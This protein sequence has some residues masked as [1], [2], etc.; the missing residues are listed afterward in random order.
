MFNVHVLFEWLKILGW[1]CVDNIVVEN[2]SLVIHFVFF[3]MDWRSTPLHL[4]RSCVNAIL[5][6]CYRTHNTLQPKHCITVNCSDSWELMK[7]NCNLYF[8]RSSR[9]VSPRLYRTSFH[10]LFQSCFAD[11]SSV[12]VWLWSCVQCAMAFVHW[13]TKLIRWRIL[14]W[15]LNDDVWSMEWDRSGYFSRFSLQLNK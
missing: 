2:D 3:C 9:L 5:T 4:A 12:C 8:D 7:A 6:F 10:Q 15:L 13:N 1:N 14:F 11:T